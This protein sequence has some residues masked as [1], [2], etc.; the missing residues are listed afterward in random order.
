MEGNKNEKQMESKNYLE[1]ID[2][3]T[4]LQDDDVEASALDYERA[5]KSMLQNESQE[6]LSIYRN[7]D[8]YKK[9]NQEKQ[10]LSIALIKL[11]H[12]SLNVSFTGQDMSFYVTDSCANE[13]LKN[14]KEEYSIFRTSEYQKEDVQR[15]FLRVFIQST[16]HLVQTG[17]V[18]DVKKEVYEEKLADILHN[19]FGVEK[20]ETLNLEQQEE[21][22]NLMKEDNF[23]D[24]YQKKMDDYYNVIL[25]I[26]SQ[27]KVDFSAGYPVLDT[28]Y[29]QKEEEKQDEFVYQFIPMND[30]KRAIYEELKKTNVLLKSVTTQDHI[31]E[32]LI[33]PDYKENFKK[34]ITAF[35]RYV[36][37]PLFARFKIFDVMHQEKLTHLEQY[38]T[39]E[40]K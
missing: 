40:E 13:I 16:I 4:F 10:L 7:L 37:I 6:F 15:S 38:L 32:I 31:Q 26:I 11:F 39:K 2:N 24:D 12:Q 17:I 27:L 30:I 25:N 18:Q 29:Y 3:L 9:V 21:F 35:D 34:S 14:M 33:S 19:R 8:F 5:I 20:E 1:E 36:I 28:S 22:E 23:T